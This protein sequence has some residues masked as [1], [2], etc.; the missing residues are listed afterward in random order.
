MTNNIKINNL[1]ELLSSNQYNI[2]PLCISNI[3]IFKNSNDIF[4]LNE[5]TKNLSNKKIKTIV[6]G[7][8]YDDN[9]VRYNKHGKRK[10]LEYEYR[11][12]LI[13]EKSK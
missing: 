13:N 3:F 6:D 5:T 8:I 12:V 4:E 11:L 10:D 9:N 2:I 7:N 1:T